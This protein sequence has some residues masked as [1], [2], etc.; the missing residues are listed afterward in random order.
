[1]ASNR[2]INI[3]TPM[4]P[5]DWALLQRELIRAK[6]DAC[7]EFFDRYFDQNGYLEMIPRWGG[8]DGPDDAIENLTDWPVLHAL[9][10]SDDIL[11]MYKAAWEG[12]L[13]Q[14][15]EAKTQEV[16]FAR[17]GMYYREFPVSFDWLHNGESM[18]V[19]GLQGLGDPYDPEFRR[20]ARRY[21]G[22]YMDEDPIAKNYDPKYKV[23]RSM[24]NGSRGPLM[25]KATALDWAGD[26]IEV[27]GRFKPGHGERS[28]EEMLK[29]FEEYNDIVGDHPMNMGA[30]S[31]VLNAF[32]STG[33]EKYSNWLV[34]YIGAWRDRT[35]ANNGIIPSNVGLDGEIGGACDGKWYGG[36]YG[37]GFT[38][39]VPQTGELSHRPFFIDRY[40]LGFGNALILSG[41]QSYVDAV[42][43][44][45]DGVNS[46]SKVINGKTVYP[47]MYGDDGWYDF[48]SEPFTSGALDVYYWSMDPNDRTRVPDNEWLNFLEG[49]DDGYPVRQMQNEMSE[50]RAKA[51]G[52]RNDMTTPDT[53][54]SDDPMAF[55]PGWV[56]TLV[57]TMIGG[58]PTTN[59]AYPMHSRIRYFNPEQRRAGLPE[60]VCS[61]VNALSADDIK[62]TLVNTNQVKP[63]TVI[64]QGGAYGEHQIEDVQVSGHKNQVDE[65]HLAIELAPGCG[66][67][68][69]MKTQ[70]Y[71]NSPTLE[72]PWV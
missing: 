22:L 58:L 46:N 62:L 32:M 42:R 40:H 60:D 21:A 63:R 31:L 67:D 3:N 1:M 38:V 9:G 41:D 52:I 69:L 51:E 44:T 20:R 33:E 37:W 48:R 17:D 43:K 55:N 57:Q 11:H 61:L 39:T 53:R 4:A 6:T 36:T 13:K 18:S 47:R 16:P 72:F 19:Y 10:G 54:M 65:N 34:D 27:E 59:A 29:H 71:T 49:R 26:Y 66:A 8:N 24:F 56:G 50:V 28:Y 2:V 5:P 14:Y 23:I 35:F 64:V 68:L 7:R 70:R 12:H 30:T 15:T 45:I 25:R